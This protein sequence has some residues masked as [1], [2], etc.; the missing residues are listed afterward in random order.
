MYKGPATRGQEQ[1]YKAARAK[2]STRI[3]TRGIPNTEY[4]KEENV[5]PVFRSR[6]SQCFDYSKLS[7]LREK[8]LSPLTDRLE[9]Y[10]TGGGFN[11]QIV[12]DDDKGSL[13]DISKKVYLGDNPKFTEDF[14]RKPKKPLVLHCALEHHKKGAMVSGHALLLIYFPATNELDIVSTYQ[15]DVDEQAAIGY[16]IGAVV[17]KRMDVIV[18]DTMAIT[19]VSF[20][21]LQ[22]YESE[23]VGW[24]VTWMAYMTYIL[25]KFPVEFWSLPYGNPRDLVQPDGTRL[26]F[27]R[28]MYQFILQTNVRGPDALR[29][30]A[31]VIRSGG[32]TRRRSRGRRSTRKGSRVQKK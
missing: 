18:N 5:A 29:T 13:N 31:E 3:M 32:G 22:K 16:V 25:Q 19:R 17:A 15:M 10:A 20:D 14:R 4:L 2:E 11:I 24:C 27:Y 6:L 28:G 21:N 12:I 8:I 26:A 9:Y 23:S 7:A 1:Q 30:L